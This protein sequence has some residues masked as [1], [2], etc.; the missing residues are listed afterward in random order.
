MRLIPSWVALLAALPLA[1]L[2]DTSA[3]L[4]APREMA[5]FQRD[6]ATRSQVIR[7]TVKRAFSGVTSAELTVHAG[8]D[9]V[10]R[11]PVT[12]GSDTFTISSP[13]IPQGGWY[14]I[15]VVQLDDSGARVARSH[16]EKV[17]VGD[18]YLVA[19]QSNAANWAETVSASRSGL[20]SM[21]DPVSGSWQT[22]RDPQPFTDIGQGSN[23]PEFAD[24]LA[25]KAGYPIGLVNTAIGGTRIE[26]WQPGM[27][28]D[29][30]QPLFERLVLA[31]KA[32]RS[33]SGFRLILWHQ[34]EGNLGSH[35]TYRA[36]F[37][38]LV[39]SLDAALGDQRVR[40]MVATA[41]FSPPDLGAADCGSPAQPADGAALQ[42]V[43]QAL[44]DGARIFPGPDSDGLVGSGYRYPG[45][46]GMCIHF[47]TAAQHLMAERWADAV[48]DLSLG[49]HG[50]SR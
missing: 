44:P 32:L 40:W 38:S 50:W 25:Q 49:N 10:S 12:A 37:L 3:L 5:V 23:W 42:R 11:T 9:Y 24:L 34:G 16:L 7:A 2:A 48:G 17:G 20:A 31:A 36:G 8:K 4:I 1:A 41:T 22:L 27:F 13:P 46:T 19:G 21:L 30:K 29:S 43:Q 47:T 15:D 28:S 26:Q 6:E 39:N 33:L 18:V 14:Q 45:P 35:S